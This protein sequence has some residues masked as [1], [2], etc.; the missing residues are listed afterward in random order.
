[1]PVT[2]ETFGV[3]YFGPAL[4]DHRMSVM[5]LGP[6]LIGLGKLCHRANHIAVA[7][8][9]VEVNIAATRRASFEV[10]L[11]L[12]V[13]DPDAVIGYTLTATNLLQSV[14]LIP[15]LSHRLS[16][17]CEYQLMVPGRRRGVFEL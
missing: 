6:A 15:V 16:W 3:E 14:G 5:D 4:E 8:S 12:V 1:M 11:E 10:L 17:D 9:A 7:H 13:R 2:T